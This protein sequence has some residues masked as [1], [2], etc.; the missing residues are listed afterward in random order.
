MPDEQGSTDGQASRVVSKRGVPRG[1]L[2]EAERLA[3]S[4]WDAA[5]HTEVSQDVFARALNVSAKGGAWR[6]RIALLRIFSLADVQGS[7][8]RLSDLGSRIVNKT[9]PS[10][11]IA[12]RRESVL[13][14]PSY[15]AILAGNEGQELPSDGALAGRFEFDYALSKADAGKA[16]GW[17]KSSMSLAELDRE[18]TIRLSDSEKAAAES[19]ST[20]PALDDADAAESTDKDEIHD[21]AQ[22]GYADTA[23]T[24][25]V[26]TRPDISVAVTLDLSNFEA[27]DVVRILQE[28]RRASL[29]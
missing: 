18:S 21:D 22:G 5:R 24:A 20:D 6:A 15:A 17:F 13:A 14:V 25:E 9:D 29:D 26:N 16:V 19:V 1:D 27:D 11:L 3:S 28:L 12:A 23:D 7:K 2:E 4:L 10:K 8:I